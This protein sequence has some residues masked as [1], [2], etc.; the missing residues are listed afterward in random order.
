MLERTESV[1]FL[2]P[3]NA[4]TSHQEIVKLV[5]DT[6][7]KYGLRPSEFDVKCSYS[8]NSKQTVH[9]LWKP[10]RFI[11]KPYLKKLALGLERLKRERGHIHYVTLA[12]G[13]K[14]LPSE[15]RVTQPMKKCAGHK[16]HCTW[17]DKSGFCDDE[18]R[19]LFKARQTKRK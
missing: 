12:N 1:V 17:V 14:E 19:E 15:I 9:V 7:K 16:K 3:F 11:S 5:K 4:N 6:L 10:E 13:V 18:C 2:P 8:S